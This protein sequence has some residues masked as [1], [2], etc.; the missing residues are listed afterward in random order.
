MLLQ[1]VQG[2]TGDEE[3]RRVALAM[4]AAHTGINEE[5]EVWVERQATDRARVATAMRQ[6][7]LARLSDLVRSQGLRLLHVGP[8]W[9]DALDVARAESGSAGVLVVRDCDSLTV[10]GGDDAQFRL[11]ATYAPVLDAEA[12]QAALSRVLLASDLDPGQVVQAV[13]RPDPPAEGATRGAL[14]PLV[15]W[16]R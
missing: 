9:A 16:M 4:V 1:P 6:G 15:E 14:A 3:W 10:L 12:A 11:A 13:L 7:V 5:C 8:W 2:I